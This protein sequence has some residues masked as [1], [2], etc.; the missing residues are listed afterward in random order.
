MK[1][2]EKTNLNQ[3]DFNTIKRFSTSSSNLSSNFISTRIEE[4]SY[5]ELCQK[6]QIQNR[7]I[8]EYL[9]WVNTLSNIIS[10]KDMTKNHLDFGTPLQERLQFIQNLQEKNLEIKKKIFEQI[11]INSNLKEKINNKKWNLNNCV[12]DFNSKKQI[13]IKETNKILEQNVQQMANELDNLLELKIEIDVVIGNNEGN[14]T[15]DDYINNST[16]KYN[17]TLSKDSNYSS[18][19]LQNV[20]NINME[21]LKKIKELYFIKKN[22]KE[23]NE[24]LMKLLNMFTPETIKENNKILCGCSGETKKK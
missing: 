20:D 10:K 24:I 6:V 22:L 12:K 14:N 3:K 17:K 15:I 11:R 23:E 7:I 21:N 8:N 19:I 16:L 5:K 4:K 1:V 9:L 13:S 2:K 18:K